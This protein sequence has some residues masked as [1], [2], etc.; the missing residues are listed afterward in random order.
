SCAYDVVLTC[1]YHIWKNDSIT[2][3]V[4][5]NSVNSNVLTAINAYFNYVQ[6]NGSSFNI[7]RD[8]FIGYMCSI[9]PRYFQY[10][11]LTNIDMLLFYIGRTTHSILNVKTKCM[12]F[13]TVHA[14][15]E[16]HNIF[17]SIH[18]I[19]HDRNNNNSLQNLMNS[20][21]SP[22]HNICQICHTNGFISYSVK[23][24]QPLLIFDISMYTIDINQTL[25]IIGNNTINVYRLRSIIYF[26]DLH[27]T[28]VLIDTQGNFWFY[29][30]LHIG[31]QARNIGNIQDGIHT[32]DLRGQKAIKVFYTKI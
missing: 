31:R 7:V 28:C 26:K 27:F 20:L 24:I 6:P 23:T 11:R 9:D 15:T 32:N 30:G 3:T 18:D 14:P 16:I 12:N 19:I 1:L 29:D 13:H 17:V 25:F 22:S 5:F 21:V 4:N 2:W 8:H 10:G